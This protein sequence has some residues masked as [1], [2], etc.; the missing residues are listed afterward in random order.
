MRIFSKTSAHENIQD[1][2]HMAFGEVTLKT[3]SC[4]V[5]MA[6]IMLVL[7]SKQ[8]MG[9]GITTTANN[10]MDTTTTKIVDETK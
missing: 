3:G 5:R 7:A 2:V 6:A 4:Q 1:I 8:M 10:V 9:V